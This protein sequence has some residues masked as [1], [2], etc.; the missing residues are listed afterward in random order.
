MYDHVLYMYVS[1]I[2]II[3]SAFQKNDLQASFAPPFG[4]F[5]T[6]S[7]FYYYFEL[8]HFRES[9]LSATLKKVSTPLL[10]FYYLLTSLSNQCSKQVA[11]KSMSA[12]LESLL[13]RNSLFHV[14]IS[15]KINRNTFLTRQMAFLKLFVGFDFF[16]FFL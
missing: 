9:F 7:I 12:E 15:G 10:S 2:Y 5:L 11:S 4:H 1:C 6:F 8:T 13:F 3:Y 16:F 14:K